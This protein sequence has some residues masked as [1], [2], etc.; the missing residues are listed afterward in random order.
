MNYRQYFVNF[1]RTRK[2]WEREIV[3]NLTDAKA[4]NV[5]VD[6]EEYKALPADKQQ[7]FLT[8]LATQ[9]KM[10]HKTTETS[11]D[12]AE[13]YFSFDNKKSYLKTMEL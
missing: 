3:H 2:G 12:G 11:K 6:T 1:V 8:A 7:K 5:T 10:Q 13:T 4:V 9:Y